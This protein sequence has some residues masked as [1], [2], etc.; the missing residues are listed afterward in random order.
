[1]SSIVTSAVI[2]EMY[3]TDKVGQ[4]RNLFS[5]IMVFSTALAPVAIGLL[6]DHGVTVS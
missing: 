5:M 4:V 6:L 1:M 3:G 2:A